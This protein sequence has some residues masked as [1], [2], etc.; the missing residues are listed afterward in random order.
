MNSEERSGEMAFAQRPMPP[1]TE[2]GML[3][4]ALV[5]AGGIYLAAN[6]PHHVTLAPAAVLLV[7]AWVVL[8]VNMTLLARVR[9]FAWDRFVMVGWRALLADTVTAGMIE[10]VFVLD[11]TRGSVLLV[12]TLMLVV[13]ALDVPLILAFTVARYQ[14]TASA[15]RA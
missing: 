11:H 1:V 7:A 4:L 2:L 12:L 15:R 14:P 5:V 8:I 6:L 9:D 10:Y 13:F 3:T